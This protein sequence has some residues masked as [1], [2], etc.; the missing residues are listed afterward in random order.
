VNFNLVELERRLIAAARQAL[1]GDSVP[2]AFQRRIMAR[3]TSRPVVDVSTVWARA[4][5]RAAASCV[6]AVVLLSAWS[7]LGPRGGS[8]DFSLQFENTVLAA[9]DSEGSN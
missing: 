1:P 4:L 6:V 7:L 8:L 2:Y 3:L 9:V 5:W